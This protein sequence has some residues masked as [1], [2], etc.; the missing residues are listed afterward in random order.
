MKLKLA[1]R[2]IENLGIVFDIQSCEHLT[3]K[4]VKD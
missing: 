2:K 3:K 1:Y 4:Y